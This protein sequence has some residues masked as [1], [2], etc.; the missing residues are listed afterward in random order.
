MG[1]LFT[2][3]GLNPFLVVDVDPI[4]ISSR[5]LFRMPYS[6]NKK[7]FLVSLPIDPDK[8]EN[9]EKDRAMPDG[10]KIERMFMGDSET[11]Q[12]KTLIAEAIDWWSLRNREEE[13][14]TARHFVIKEAV[15][16]K[17]FPPCIQNILNGLSDGRKRSLLIMFNFLRQRNGNGK[18]SKTSSRNGTGGI[19]LLSGKA[20]SGRR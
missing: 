3:D 1:K 20:S 19:I 7:S 17:Y 18:T 11:D 13:K 6:L 2:D 16:K 9:F 15:P 12:A 5:H 8:I 4:L 14:K 10:L